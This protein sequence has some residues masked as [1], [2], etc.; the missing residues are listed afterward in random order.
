MN[1]GIG[2]F[3]KTVQWHTLDCNQG[4]PHLYS[5]HLETCFKRRS[6]YHF[7]AL[8]YELRK[9]FVNLKSL[10][11]RSVLYDPVSLIFTTPRTYLL[12]RI[13]VTRDYTWTHRILLQVT[14]ESFPAFNDLA[15]VAVWIRSGGWRNSEHSRWPW[16]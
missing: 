6:A 15:W 11:P 9:L 10:L 14:K 13:Y 3:T 5:A 8:E 7:S 2:R 12:T 1:R 16:N 4:P